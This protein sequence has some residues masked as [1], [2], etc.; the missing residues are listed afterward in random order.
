[1]ANEILE[2]AR[3]FCEQE[4]EDSMLYAYIASKEKDEN[5]GKILE[6]IAKDEEGHYKFWK[7][8][9][10]KDCK[11]ES[12]N[13]KML[14]FLFLRKLFG[15]TFTLKYLENK[16]KKAIESY[17]K[18]LSELKGEDAQVLM[19]I[20]QDEEIH[21]KTEIQSL[22]EK[23][24]RYM[25]FIIL[26]LADAIVEINGVHAGFLGVTESTIVTGIAGMVVG[27]SAAIS[28]ASAAYL[29]AK[30]EAGKSPRTSALMTG[31]AYISAVSVLALPYFLIRKMLTAF[32]VSISIAILMIA[33]FTYYGSTLQEKDFKREFIESTLLMLG[34]AFVT[35][36]FG[37]LLGTAFGIRGIL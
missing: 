9:Y 6:A 33:S 16:E 26:G 4:Y 22:D 10:G 23:V 15:I 27:V 11:T 25:S 37:D 24:V 5:R 19:K 29:Q 34:T 13:S 30:H 2:K 14:F 20:I 21:E 28:M 3:E 35:Y 31:L 17:K 1:M 8:L 7:K 32:L 12:I 18:M 36:F